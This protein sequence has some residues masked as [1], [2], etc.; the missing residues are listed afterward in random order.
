MS[1]VEY[2][3]IRGVA[4]VAEA[5][6]SGVGSLIAAISRVVSV[7]RRKSVRATKVRK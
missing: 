3:Y 5:H 4:V 7:G 1:A 2:R 6:G